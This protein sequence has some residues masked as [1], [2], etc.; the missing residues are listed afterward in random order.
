MSEEE[1]NFFIQAV[2]LSTT[3]SWTTL[4]PQATVARNAAFRSFYAG[5]DSPAAILV[6]MDTSRVTAVNSASVADLYQKIAYGDLQFDQFADD[7]SLASVLPNPEESAGQHARRVFM[8]APW[9]QCVL[10][11]LGVVTLVEVW[12]LALRRRCWAAVGGLAVA[13]A[14]FVVLASP[15]CAAQ[16]ASWLPF[17]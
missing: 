8:S 9:W 1:E 11:A 5:L 10:V 4:L 6:D 3:Q 12:A 7:F 2:R 14:A 15:P 17:F 16:V 13:T